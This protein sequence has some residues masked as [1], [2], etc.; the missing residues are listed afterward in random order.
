MQVIGGNVLEVL[1][2]T[3]RTILKE[4]AAMALRQ[5]ACRLELAFLILTVAIDRRR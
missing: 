3:V 5:W 4:A 1:R 2:V